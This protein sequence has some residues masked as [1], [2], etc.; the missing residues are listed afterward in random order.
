[1]HLG[2]AKATI[3]GFPIITIEKTTNY[4]RSRGVSTA[5]ANDAPEQEKP[6]HAGATGS[7]SDNGTAGSNS[8]GNY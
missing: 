1:M 5:S 3:V 8:G 7:N 6:T 2:G 4:C